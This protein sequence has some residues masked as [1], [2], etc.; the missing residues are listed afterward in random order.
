[1]RGHGSHKIVGPLVL[2]DRDGFLGAVKTIDRCLDRLS[3]QQPILVETVIPEIRKQHDAGPAGVVSIGV[4]DGVREKP[5]HGSRPIDKSQ[6]FQRRELPPI[7]LEMC[8]KIRPDR[9]GGQIHRRIGMDSRPIL[10]IDLRPGVTA[11]VLGKDADSRIHIA[12]PF[13]PR[14]QTGIRPIGQHRLGQLIKQGAVDATGRS[15]QLAA[16]DEVQHLR[17]HVIPEACKG[18]LTHTAE[19]RIVVCKRLHTSSRSTC[20]RQPVTRPNKNSSLQGTQGQPGP[21]RTADIGQICKHFQCVIA[22]RKSESH[23]DAQVGAITDLTGLPYW[24]RHAAVPSR[25]ADQS[26]NTHRRIEPE[27]PSPQHGNLFSGRVVEIFGTM[28]H[29]MQQLAG[30]RGTRSIRVLIWGGRAGCRRPAD[31]HAAAIRQGKTEVTSEY[32]AQ[33]ALAF[34]PE[35]K[36]RAT[37]TPARGQVGDIHAVQFLQATNI[38][39][40]QCLG[41]IHAIDL[42]IVHHLDVERIRDL[43]RRTLRRVDLHMDAGRGLRARLG[44]N[45]QPGPNRMRDPTPQGIKKAVDWLNHGAALS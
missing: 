34:Q 8:G 43:L 6:G 16:P 1:M 2:L 11:D 7:R 28:S 26:L 24:N 13:Y 30:R 20:L 40:A 21:N 22:L 32:P 14:V 36:L 4:I 38:R 3:R 15:R 31:S 42:R 29:A 23:V 12:R 18:L 17:G 10:E 9:V 44:K 39:V 27:W 19:I 35:G 25:T 41:D 33:E 37:Q 45:G 5:A